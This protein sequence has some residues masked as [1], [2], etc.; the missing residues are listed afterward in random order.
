MSDL[1]LVE[2]DDLTP[3]ATIDQTKAAAMVADAIA[4]A[5]LA[6][7]CLGDTT[8]LN[9]QQI[10]AAKAVLRG[11]VLRWND[12][13]TGAIGSQTAGP[14]AQTFD[15]RQPRRVLFWPSEIS[16]LQRI[17][18]EPT[19]GGAFSIDT[20]AAEPMRSHAVFF[21]SQDGFETVGAVAFDDDDDSYFGEL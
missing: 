15:T 17:C 10:A 20:A 1:P 18:V 9:Y 7:P 21:G 3:F 2:V 12:S 4:M 8:T 6:A 19:S 13:G 5:I 16:T 14:Y 11:A